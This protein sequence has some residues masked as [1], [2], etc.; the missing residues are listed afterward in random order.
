MKNTSLYLLT[1]TL[2][3]ASTLGFASD[4]FAKDTVQL[5]SPPAEQTDYQMTPRKDV[6][7]ANFQ[8][9]DRNKNIE[10]KIKLKK[11]SILKKIAEMQ[12]YEKSPAMIDDTYCTL[13]EES[14]K[15][16]YSLTRMLD[17]SPHPRTENILQNK[18]VLFNNKKYH[19][20]VTYNE[21]WKDISADV[22]CMNGICFRIKVY[23]NGKEVR[24]LT[25]PKVNLSK[26]VKKGQTIG[27]AEVA[28]FKFTIKVDDIQTNAKGV[29]LLQFKLD[30]VG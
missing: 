24:D 26:K 21:D 10:N 2:F 7:L 29:T 27:I 18:P 25:T 28:P 4:A 11:D 17:Y 5:A 6:S 16:L 3:A 9:L 20:S 8:N 1:S 14:P 19:F 23:E 15:N 22:A 13:L 12:N 30:L